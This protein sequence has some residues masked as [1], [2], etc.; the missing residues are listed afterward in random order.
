MTVRNL[1]RLFKPES[2][3]LIG[4][5]KRAGSVGALVARNLLHGG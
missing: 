2:A 4:A 5:S 3:V 1:N